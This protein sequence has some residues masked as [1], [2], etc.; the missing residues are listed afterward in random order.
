MYLLMSASD[1]GCGVWDLRCG[2]LC[3]C[4]WQA[5]QLQC[6]GLVAPQH[7]GS[8]FLY[9]GSILHPRLERRNLNCQGSPLK[10]PFH[11]SFRTGL[12]VVNSLCFC[13]SENVLI[14][15]MED[16]FAFLVVLS[17]IVGHL[18]HHYSPSDFYIWQ[19][20][21]FLSVQSYLL[22]CM[23]FRLINQNTIYF[24]PFQ[25]LFLKFYF[26]LFVF[27]TRNILYQ[28]IAS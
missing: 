11:I 9:Q 19:R 14:S 28:G 1:L 21:V 15:F 20:L 24:F 25:N 5:Q 27:N 2:L 16:I 13:L 4:G 7:V 17:G 10:T 22:C 12:P 26:Y 8:Q 18:A 23:C 6:K 3:S